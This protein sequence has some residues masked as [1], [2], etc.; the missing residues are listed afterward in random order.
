LFEALH[1]GIRA[2][3][4]ALG[5][6]FHMAMT[7]I[8]GMLIALMLVERPAMRHEDQ[9]IQL[10]IY[11]PAAV[12]W[13]AVD[14]PSLW[15]NWRVAFGSERPLPVASAMRQH[16]LPWLLRPVLAIWW[17]LHF[18]FGALGVLLANQISKSENLDP[19]EGVAL[20]IFLAFAYGLAANGFVVYAMASLVRS[21]RLLERAWSLRLF[22]D[23]GLAL[24]GILLARLGVKLP[25]G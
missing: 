10:W 16:R 23:V 8:F 2:A 11:I 18:A 5:F 1:H 7:L 14:L 3:E 6:F 19:H 17:L 4:T 22:V 20:G 15:N 25:T 12:L 24:L 13:I 21:R 9:L